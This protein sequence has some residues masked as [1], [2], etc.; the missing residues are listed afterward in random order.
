MELIVKNKFFSLGGSS[1]V[2]DENNKDA[3]FVKGKVFSITRKKFVKDL[4]GKK[5]F[6]VRNK[7]WHLFKRKALIYDANKKLVVR[8]IRDFKIRQSYTI[9]GAEEEIKVIANGS[10]GLGFDMSIFMGGKE[11][12]HIKRPF[13]TW[14]DT[15]NL[16]IIDPEDAAIL[17][18]IVIGIDNIQDKARKN[19]N[20]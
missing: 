10:V 13:V 20:N 2:L 8:I 5:L 9:E 14:T 3:F 12:G 4:N 11:I 16:T 19:A 1:K 15:F 7:F 17:V 18:A 6:M